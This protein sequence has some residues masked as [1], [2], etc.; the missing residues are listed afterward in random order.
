MAYGRTRHRARQPAAR[1]QQPATSSSQ[2]RA[3]S[4]QRGIPWGV[5]GEGPRGSQLVLVTTQ[6]APDCLPKG[7][8]LRPAGFP[9]TY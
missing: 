3:T 5:L 2:Q 1:S 7:G 6:I 4:N 9:N 8:W